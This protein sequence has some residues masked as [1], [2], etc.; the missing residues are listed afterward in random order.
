[1]HVEINLNSH[2]NLTA[3]LNAVGQMRVSRPVNAHYILTLMHSRML[4]GHVEWAVIMKLKRL[5][6]PHE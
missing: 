4:S 1:M 6:Q 2:V 3:R 5:F